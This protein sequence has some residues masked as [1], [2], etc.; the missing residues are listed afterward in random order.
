[1]IVNALVTIRRIQLADHMEK[2]VLYVIDFYEDDLKSE[3]ENVEE[4]LTALASH[5]HPP[6]RVENIVISDRRGTHSYGEEIAPHEGHKIK[7]RW[8]K[9]LENKALF[10]ANIDLVALRAELDALSAKGL[11]DRTSHT[12]D[13]YDGHGF[14]TLVSPTPL[15]VEFVCAC[16]GAP[17]PYPKDEHDAPP[18]KRSGARRR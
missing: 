14:F 15:G 1:M 18:P 7:S 10:G 17:L 3:A 9:T 4:F 13:A 11:V 8:K 6:V 12:F 16:R 2:S 5:E